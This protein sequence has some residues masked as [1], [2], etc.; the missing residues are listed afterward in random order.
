[1]SSNRIDLPPPSRPPD[2]TRRHFRRWLR[3]HRRVARETPLR[4]LLDRYAPGISP[5]AAY[6]AAVAEGVRGLRSYRTRYAG[7]WNLINWE[8]PD[9]VLESIWGVARGNL[10]QRRLRTAKGSPLFVASTDA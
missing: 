1:M 7:F 2:A 3:K 4:A 8:L 5:S 6:R 9:S 10:R